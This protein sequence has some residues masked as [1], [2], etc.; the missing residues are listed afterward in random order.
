MDLLT[1]RLDT[2][3]LHLTD[4]GEADL[5]PAWRRFPDLRVVRRREG[6]GALTA[7]AWNTDPFDFWAFDRA[8]D[9]AAASQQ[10]LAL[11]CPSPAAGAV[12]IAVL[13]RLQRLAPRRNHASSCP[14]FD[15]AL[16]AYA[17]RHDL[18]RPLVRADLDH[19][20]DAWQWLLHVRPGADL[21]LQLAVLLHDIERLDSEPDRRVEHLAADY[22][23]FKDRHAEAGAAL[24]EQ[25]L[26]DAGVEPAVAGDAAAL[27]ARHERADGDPRRTALGDA[28]A[29]SFFSLNS[30]GYLRYFG[31]EQTRKKVMYTLDRMSAAA[32]DELAVLRLCSEVRAMIEESHGRS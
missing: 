10:P 21:A 5:R 9:A 12:L 26:R 30:P 24:A 7:D 15:R 18:T 17:A 6:T 27:I 3:A 8:A 25:L 4:D 31:A 23:A 28:D 19:A 32:R 22:Q 1:A 13:V 29:L 14:A 20:I 11:S 16:A 2:I